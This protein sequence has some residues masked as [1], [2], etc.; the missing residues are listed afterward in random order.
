MRTEHQVATLCLNRDE[1]QAHKPWPWKMRGPVSWL[2]RIA[3]Q[4]Y[5][6]WRASGPMI[7]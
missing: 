1:G 4:E 5:L 3:I 6:Q 2:V 7:R